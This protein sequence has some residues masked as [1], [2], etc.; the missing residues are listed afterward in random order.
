[1][2]PGCGVLPQHAPEEAGWWRFDRWAPAGPQSLRGPR[3]P[4]AAAPCLAVCSSPPGSS[5]TVPFLGSGAWADRGVILTEEQVRK[6]IYQ[7]TTL[8]KTK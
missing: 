5:E 4:E 7:L 1:M 3:S 8:R 6:S 2:G